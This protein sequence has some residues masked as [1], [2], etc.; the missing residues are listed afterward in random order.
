MIT[1]A[2][3]GH[4]ISVMYAEKTP[5]DERDYIKHAIVVMSTDTNPSKILKFKCGEHAPPGQ[6]WYAF[7]ELVQVDSNKFAIFAIG[8]VHDWLD[9][10]AMIYQIDDT[11]G[12]VHLRNDLESFHNFD[13]ILSKFGLKVTWKM[14][15]GQE[16]EKSM[17]SIT[18]VVNGNILHE[19][20]SN[21][22]RPRIAVVDD[23][24]FIIYDCFY[25]FSPKFNRRNS[26]SFCSISINDKGKDIKVTKEDISHLIDT[27]AECISDIEF[28]RWS[29]PNLGVYLLVVAKFI[30]VLDMS[31]HSTIATFPFKLETLGQHLDVIQIGSEITLSSHYPHQV[32]R[33]GKND[34]GEYYFLECKA[35][36]LQD[37]HKCRI[38]KYTEWK[39]YHAN[40]C[41]DILYISPPYE[42]NALLSIQH[43]VK[44]FLS[45]DCFC[46]VLLYL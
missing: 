21:S 37:Y 39:L 30:R 12:V 28:I 23:D 22:Y 27:D 26:F 19:W 43:H 35:D 11:R 17:I 13:G 44:E 4:A 25:G 8:S 16:T 2:L 15:G 29:T 24:K 6:E 40:L 46:L 18:S 3:H 32:Y 20:I 9:P 31:T 45:S 36:Y 14:H 10:Y 1:R 33:L 7:Y 38:G 5:N 42:R 34:T 41:S